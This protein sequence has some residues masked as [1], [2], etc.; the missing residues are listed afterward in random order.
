MMLTRL[1]DG[2]KPTLRFK[3]GSNASYSNR[4]MTMTNLP[5]KITGQN[6]TKRSIVIETYLTDD[7]T[8]QFKAEGNP[9]AWIEA[10]EV[11]DLAMHA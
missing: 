4:P 1:D 2:S 3:Y 11:I 6:P 8:V 7:G 9:N 10:G 5:A